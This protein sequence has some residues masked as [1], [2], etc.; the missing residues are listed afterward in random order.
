MGSILG[1]SCALVPGVPHQLMPII[2]RTNDDGQ[3]AHLHKKFQQHTCT[4]SHQLCQLTRRHL[5]L[6]RQLDRGCLQLLLCCRKL[7]LH[8]AVVRMCMCV[9]PVHIQRH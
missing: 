4:A 2:L 3:G 7:I 1:T 5:L 6:H 9:K 8:A